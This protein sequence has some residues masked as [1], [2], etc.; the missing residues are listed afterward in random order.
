MYMCA[1]KPGWLCHCGEK[2]IHFV[3]FQVR[4]RDLSL[5]PKV[6]HTQAEEYLKGCGASGERYIAKAWDYFDHEYVHN[7]VGT[8]LLN[9]AS[10]WLNFSLLLQNWYHDILYPIYLAIDIYIVHACIVLLCFAVS[11]NHITA[12]CH[13]S[14]KQN[15][16][17]HVVKVIWHVK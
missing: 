4:Q 1:K 10:I 6:S 11:K 2:Q 12:N 7:I 8:Y 13:H 14:M 9:N 3:Y 17:A 16:T 5:L 15:E